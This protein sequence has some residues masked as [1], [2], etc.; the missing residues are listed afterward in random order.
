MKVAHISPPKNPA[1]IVATRDQLE[2][3][4]ALGYG[5]LVDV[6]LDDDAYTRK[7]GRLN[8][9]YVGRMLK[10]DMKCV[11]EVLAAAAAG[12]E[13]PRKFSVSGA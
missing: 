6:L 4:R 12:E 9:S 11:N 5:P 10:L 13:N 1:D 8:K 7:S 2:H 3:L